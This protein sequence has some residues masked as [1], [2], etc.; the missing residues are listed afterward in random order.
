M[1]ERLKL[2]CSDAKLSMPIS[3]L[4]LVI[5]S[6]SVVDIFGSP[7]PNIVTLNGGCCKILHNNS[8]FPTR[9]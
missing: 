7:Q 2:I 5:A 3:T 8:E 6:H 9:A 4:E 1:E